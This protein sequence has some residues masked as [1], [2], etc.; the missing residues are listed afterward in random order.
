[1]AM[2]T[3]QMVDDAATIIKWAREFLTTENPEMRRPAGSQAV[4]PFVAPSLDSNSFYLSFHPEISGW[5]EGQIEKL[6]LDQI[7][8][9]EGLRPPAPGDRSRKSLLLVFPRLPDNQ[10]GVLDIVQKNVKTRFMESGL[11][12]GQ[13]YR[14]CEEGSIY[15][16]AFR[17]SQSPL[18]LIAIRY[19]AVHD[20]L[21]C[22][23]DRDWF[24]A[25]DLRFGEKFR[26][27]GDLAHFNSHLI[28][29]YKKAKERWQQ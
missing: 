27:K 26:R 19:M 14:T 11:M 16:R 18:P 4:C 8:A 25:Y 21:F 28:A 7:A 5:D 17:V 13:F 6:V 10:A 12:L 29:Y 1:M 22:G 23:E 9:F 20:I 2:L 3:P 15:N 24:N